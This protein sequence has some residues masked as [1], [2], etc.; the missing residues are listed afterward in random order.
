M[1]QR[2]EPAVFPVC[3]ACLLPAAV[4]RAP[5]DGAPMM[6][7]VPI[8]LIAFDI[9]NATRVLV[10]LWVALWQR[11]LAAVWGIQAA[12][13]RRAPRAATCASCAQWLQ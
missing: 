9:T 13:R 1:W 11:V 2:G 8:V 7:A 10:E 4:E 12:H 6:R 3:I 5:A